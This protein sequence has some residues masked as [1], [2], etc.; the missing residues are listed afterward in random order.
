MSNLEYE[1]KLK[2]DVDVSEE[3]LNRKKRAAA[4]KAKM[5]QQDFERERERLI[6]ERNN[7]D[8]LDKQYRIIDKNL[9]DLQTRSRVAE[10]DE[11]RK[12]FEL[13]TRKNTILKLLE[14]SKKRE[15]FHYDQSKRLSS[16]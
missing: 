4:E 12:I 15:F 6:E 3:H 10:E 5:A 16:L 9:L 8:N 2:E 14:E 7:H 11:Q 1:E 13:S